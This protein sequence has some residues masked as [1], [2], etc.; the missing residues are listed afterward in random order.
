ME[1]RLKDV[2]PGDAIKIEDGS[3]MMVQSVGD[4]A[5]VG[6]FPGTLIVKF[7]GGKVSYGP[8]LSLVEVSD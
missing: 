3:F 8:A 7:K 6:L 2:S 5:V 4:G 1:K